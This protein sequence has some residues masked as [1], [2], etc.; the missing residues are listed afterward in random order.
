MEQD[1]RVL[2]T[3]VTLILQELLDSSSDS[4]GEELQ[5]IKHCINVRRHVPRVENY[6]QGIVAALTENEFKAHFRYYLPIL[7]IFF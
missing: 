7:I 4:D 5:I 1:K 2:L 3:S 6:V